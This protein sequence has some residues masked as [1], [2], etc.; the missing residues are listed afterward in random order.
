MCIESMSEAPLP[1]DLASLLEAT[2]LVLHE[3]QLARLRTHLVEIRRIDARGGQFHSKCLVF[4]Q[5]GS[6][7][8]AVDPDLTCLAIAYLQRGTMIGRV[9]QF[10]SVELAVRTF[11]SAPEKP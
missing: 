5:R 4:A 8:L 1:G 3:A 10:A 2:G 11:L 9:Q 6:L 7:A